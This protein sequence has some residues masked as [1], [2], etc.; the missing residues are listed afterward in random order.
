VSQ[1]IKILGVDPGYGRCGWGVITLAGN[2]LEANDYGVIETSA[3]M[4]FSERLLAVHQALCD[5]LKSHQPQE[6]A[7]EQ[8]FF[9]KNVKTAID[10]G[11]ARG[12]IV[13]TCIQAG[14]EVEE[15]KPAEI[16][17]AVSGYGA[18]P[19]LQ[20][21]RMVKMLLGLTK[22]PK[23]DDAADALA[24]A[25]CHAHSRRYSHILKR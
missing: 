25:I 4:R 7:V 1:K 15:Y 11:Q 20:I 3:K 23:P 8:L 16:K 21:Q 5:I 18:A 14:L 19:K 2:H 9:A 12:V 6:V 24:I 10:V 17:I 22:V 13:L